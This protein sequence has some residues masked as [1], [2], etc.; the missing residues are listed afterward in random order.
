MCVIRIVIV[1]RSAIQL[2]ESEHS[3]MRLVEQIFID[4]SKARKLYTCEDKLYVLIRYLVIGEQGQAL[5][6]LLLL[7]PSPQAASIQFTVQIQQ[8]HSNKQNG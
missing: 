6:L 5:L 3:G 8:E 4:A 7:F 1:H 2:T